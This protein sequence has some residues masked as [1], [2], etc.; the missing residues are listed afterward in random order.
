MSN[1]V[2]LEDQIQV[3]TDDIKRL[4]SLMVGVVIVTIGIVLT[5]IFTLGAIVT[6]SLAD[7]QATSQQIRDEVHAQNSKIDALTKSLQDN[8]KATIK[9]N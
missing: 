8:Q 9:T 4:N 1:G 5:L 3:T 6:S 7:K 2:D